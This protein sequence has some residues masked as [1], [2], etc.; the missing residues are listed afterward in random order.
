MSSG[1]TRGWTPVRGK[2]ARQTNN[3]E[4]APSPFFRTVCSLMAGV[5]LGKMDVDWLYGE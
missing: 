2:K 3:L 4:Q 5:L 1:L